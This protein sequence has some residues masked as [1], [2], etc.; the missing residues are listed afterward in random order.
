MELYAEERNIA[1]VMPSGENKFYVDWPSNKFFAFISEELPDFV[2]GLFPVSKR[3]EDTYIA[4][5][6]MGGFGTAVHALNF[7]ERFYAFGPISAS[8]RLINPAALAGPI[9]PHNLSASVMSDPDPPTS[10]V[11]ACR[12]ACRRREKVPEVLSRL[13]KEGFPV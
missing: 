1:V 13:R 9:D 5:L 8:F 4:G 12:K 7:P 11:R 10:T 3:P 6:S 2:T